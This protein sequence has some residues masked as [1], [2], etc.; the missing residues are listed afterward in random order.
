MTDENARVNRELA[1]QLRERVA[2]AALGGPAAVRT[3]HTARGK[4]LPR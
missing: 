3:R 1:A 2:A 4:L